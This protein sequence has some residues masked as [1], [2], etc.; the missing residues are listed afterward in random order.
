ML[1]DGERKGT[2]V[3]NGTFRNPKNRI[4]LLKRVREMLGLPEKGE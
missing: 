1:V 3:G 2:N 4:E